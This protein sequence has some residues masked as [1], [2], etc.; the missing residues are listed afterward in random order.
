MR[1]ELPSTVGGTISWAGD[2]ELTEEGGS[3][4]KDVR[5]NPLLP[6]HGCGL[7]A[8]SSCHWLHHPLQSWTWHL[9]AKI[10][11]TQVLSF[12]T[13][14]WSYKL[15]S[16]LEQKETK[17][18]AR[19]YGSGV[20]KERLGISVRK[21]RCDQHEGAGGLYTVNILRLRKRAGHHSKGSHCSM[22]DWITWTLRVAVSPQKVGLSVTEKKCQK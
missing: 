6:A 14:S 12:F 2:P 9:L 1:K 4:H 5:I 22:M 7:A 19:R 13:F 3:K 8:S 20:Q 21:K 10:S 15:M 17:G 11:K 16:F 18:K